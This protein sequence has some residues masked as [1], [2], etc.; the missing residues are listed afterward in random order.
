MQASDA[1]VDTPLKAVWDFSNSSQAADRRLED[2]GEPLDTGV[3]AWPWLIV[4]RYAM[5]MLAAA[6]IVLMKWI[7]FLNHGF[8]EALGTLLLLALLNVVASRTMQL[9]TMKFG[10][11]A[12][13]WAVLVAD[14]ICLT[15]MLGFSGGVVNPLS[16]L[17]IVPVMLGAIGLPRGYAWSL[18]VCSALGFGSL[19]YLYIPLSLP[20][21]HVY[22]GDLLW[23]FGGMWIAFVISASL[24][25][26]FLGKLTEAVLS[27]EKEVIE[28]QRA[29]SRRRQVASIA[30]LAA[31]AA[32]ELNSPLGTIAVVAHE[33][34]V[35]CKKLTLGPQLVA[36]AQL[37]RSEVDRCRNALRQIAGREDGRSAISISRIDPGLLLQSTIEKLSA[38]EQKRVRVEQGAAELVHG[39][40]EALEKAILALIRNGLESHRDALVEVRYQQKGKT[41]EISV[42]DNG[43]GF[44]P[45]TLHRVT[46]PFFTTKEEGGSRGMGL[47]LVAVLMDEL[48]GRLEV[49]SRLHQGANVRLTIP[50]GATLCR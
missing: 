44:T 49:E 36:D 13:Y 20:S 27:R 35:A 26:L 46:E 41:V 6:L 16:A 10:T 43:P 37:I 4:V 1:T 38:A 19:F 42:C 8:L 34:E 22:H 39:P 21:S 47:F 50:Q 11:K 18:V 12:L 9:R 33:M 30:A 7:G 15:V 40:A 3:L 25:T 24:I 32:H 14:I 45:G 17:L 5:A 28:L 31:G 2:N 29:V 48:H 23:H